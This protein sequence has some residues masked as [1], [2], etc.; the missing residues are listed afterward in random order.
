MPAASSARWVVGVGIPAADAATLYGST[1]GR[2]VRRFAATSELVDWLDRPAAASVFAFLPES[3]FDLELCAALIS[4][5]QR[6]D[7]PLGLFPVTGAAAAQA[8]AVRLAELALRPRPYPRDVL[9]YGDFL[10]HAPPSLAHGFGRAE[11][12]PFLAA[13]DTGAGALVFHGH[14]NGADFRVG[15][16]ALC[17]QADDLRPA[18]GRPGERFLACQAGGRCRLEHKGLRSFLGASQVHAGI[19]VLLSC[20]GV[21]PADGLFGLRF[22]FSQ[23][24]LRGDHVRVVVSSVRVNANTAA[25]GV[26]VARLLAAGCRAGELPLYLNSDSSAGGCFLCIGDPEAAPTVPAAL[27]AAAPLAAALPAAVPQAAPLSTAAPSPRRAQPP[28]MPRVGLP[29][30]MLGADPLSTLAAQGAIEELARKA[31]ARALQ[32]LLVE[33]AAAAGDEA[34]GPAAALA[35]RLQH[36]ALSW[37][38]EPDETPV[39]AALRA[40]RQSNGGLDRDLCGFFATI[41]ALRGPDLYA[42]L[43]PAADAGAEQPAAHRHGCGARLFRSVLPAPGVAGAERWLWICER[44]GNAADTPVGGLPAR[45]DLTSPRSLRL[46]L[47]P[48]QAAGEVWI[49]A[50]QAPL[51]GCRERPLAPLALSAADL[52]SPIALTLDPVERGPGLRRVGVAVVWDGEFMLSQGVA[53]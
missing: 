38:R 52:A 47:P 49:T 40:R 19:V 36:D 8:A 41:L 39:A 30:R 22:L 32:A 13:L 15:H 4:V 6:R 20:A 28:A 7:L 44:C 31:A 50:S 48:L 37:L 14:G 34:A 53:A 33:L 9:F 51:G 43:A 25:Q 1:L 23:A 27:R 46:T 10:A 26:A 45:L 35:D 3:Q 42:Y 18:A 24:L 5:A 11:V 16:S 17:V 2:E 12:E 29:G 21:A